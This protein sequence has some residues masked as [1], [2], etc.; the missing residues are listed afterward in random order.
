MQDTQ[1]NRSSMGEVSAEQHPRSPTTTTVA[2]PARGLRTPLLRSV[3]QRIV[4]SWLFCTLV[5]FTVWT[6]AHLPR[7]VASTLGAG[8]GRLFYQL[9]RYRRPLCLSNLSLAFPDKSAAERLAI[10]KASYIHLGR[11]G[12]DFC[13]FTRLNKED[14][15]G[16]FIVPD[17]DAFDVTRAAFAEGNGVIGVASH[18]GFW[19]LSGFASNVLGFEKIVSVSRKLPIPRLEEYLT[20][21]RERLGNQIVSQD[22][23]LRPIL[24]ALKENRSAGILT[25]LHAGREHPWIPFFGREASTFDTCAK[26][27]LKTGAP[28]LRV[29]MFRRPDG[30][31]RWSVKRIEPGPLIGSEEEKVRHI[32]TAMNRSLEDAIREHPEQWVWMNKRWREKK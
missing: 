19:E 8:A 23:A 24:R 9:E 10:L 4:E 14:L 32:L 26:L 30:R 17:A 3:R 18:I 28:L 13:R 5:R 6:M 22:G 11:C 25:D 1:A 15:L 29:V 31:Y 27:H 12:A 20:R 16:K 21:V 2:V 7:G